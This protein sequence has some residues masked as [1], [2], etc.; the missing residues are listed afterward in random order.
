MPRKHQGKCVVFDVGGTMWMVG[1]LVVYGLKSV[2]IPWLWPVFNQIFLMVF[3]AIWLRR[4]GKL[5]G[6]EWITF[7]FGD[8]LGARASHLINVIF[9]L[10]MVVGMLAFGFLGIGKLAAEFSPW[11]FSADPHMN[12]KIYGLIVVALRVVRQMTTA[13][14][15]LHNEIKPLLLRVNQIA[16]DA[17]RISSLTAIQ[18]ERVDQ[19]MASTASR[20]EST[21]SVL[22]NVMAGPVGQ[23]AAA[24]TAFKAAFS[25]FRDWKGRR[26][27]HLQ[28]DDDDALFV[29]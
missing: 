12:D 19:L 5:T 27:Q 15:E 28:Q 20:L 3:L 17:A 2:F 10:I 14:N 1:L 7:R 26:R 29:G 16:D 23:T 13:T 24:V 21:M 8:G 6:A 9:A 4:S 22:Q 25:A 11:R 18:A